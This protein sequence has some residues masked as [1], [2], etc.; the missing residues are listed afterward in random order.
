MADDSGYGSA[1]NVTQTATTGNPLQPVY[2]QSPPQITPTTATAAGSNYNVS[3]DRAL[4]MFQRAS[5]LNNAQASNNLSNLLA[6]QG[7]TGGDAAQAMTTLQGKIAASQAPTLSNLIQSAQSMGLNQALANAGFQEQTGLANQ[8]AAN[9]TSELDLSALL[10]TNQSNAAAANDAG[11]RLAAYLMQNYGID[12]GAFGSIL[13]AGLG[14]AQAINSSGLS[15]QLGLAGQTAD[16]QNQAT[17][18]GWQGLGRFFGIGG[19]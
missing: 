7:I 9:Q 1:P 5:A 14:G 17:Q 8:N 16:A 15:G 13:N 10:G 3:P 6:S 4:A 18:Q 11:Q 2:L 12:L 19:G